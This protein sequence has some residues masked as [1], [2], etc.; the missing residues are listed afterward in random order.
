MKTHSSKTKRPVRA[1]KESFR[2]TIIFNILSNVNR[3]RIFRSLIKHDKLTGRDIAKILKIS[4][5]LASQ[6][7]RKLETSGI[8]V[9]KKAGR[10]AYYSLNPRNQSV[11]AVRIAL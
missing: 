10:T 3:F 5:S 6:H 7:L 4:N 11:M 9:K 1:K 2:L 8:L